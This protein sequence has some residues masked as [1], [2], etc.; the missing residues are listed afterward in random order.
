MK[1]YST[2]EHLSFRKK[3]SV[4][5]HDS[6]LQEIESLQDKEVSIEL[7]NGELIEGVVKE[8]CKNVISISKSGNWQSKIEIDI[9]NIEKLSSSEHPYYSHKYKISLREE[10]RPRSRF[11]Y[12]RNELKDLIGKYVLIN[13]DGKFFDGKVIETIYKRDEKKCNVIVVE[14]LDGEIKEIDDYRLRDL[15]VTGSS[16]KVHQGVLAIKSFESDLH[17]ELENNF[18]GGDLDALTNKKVEP[19]EL[20]E[21]YFQYKI[22]T[23]KGMNI[24]F[25]EVDYNWVNE[26]LPETASSNGKASKPL[27][28]DVKK[29]RAVNKYY[30]ER[31]KFVDFIVRKAQL[32][33]WTAYHKKQS[34]GVIEVLEYV[35]ELGIATS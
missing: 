2:I 23:L 16:L 14:S 24:I 26:I 3:T 5:K 29:A 22:D 28:N 1:A 34:D 10:K 6:T 20:I 33:D 15:E 31:K 27:Y 19:D 21:K 8:V 13:Y 12:S 4:R 35:Y 9:E 30:D 7:T 18:S 11:R 25:Y 17:I 32:V